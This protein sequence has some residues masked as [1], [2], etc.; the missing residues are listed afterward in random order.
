[1]PSRLPETGRPG[2]RAGWLLP[3]G[4]VFATAFA[5]FA[6]RGFWPVTPSVASPGPASASAVPVS[7]GR[8]VRTD[9]AERQ[10][11]PGTLGYRG[12][13]SVSNELPA[14]II[15]WL[16]AA[17]QVIR[18]GQALYRIDGQSVTLLYGSIP[19]WRSFQPGMTPG[20]DVRE[21]N[22]NL[23]ALGFDPDRQIALG[24]QFG[25]ATVAAVEL[26]QRAHGMPETGSIPLGEVA[27]LPGPLLISAESASMG[28]PVGAGN[29]VLSGTSTTPSVLVSLTPGGPAARA[30]DSVLVTLP[31]GTTTVPGTVTSVGRVATVS[32]QSAA[33]AQGAGSSQGSGGTQ[34]PQI[35]VTIGLRR[36]SIGSG[37]DQA[38]V[39]V[40]ITEADDRGVLAVP[41]TA[42]LAL[43]D[44]SFAVRTAGNPSRLIPVT[45]HLFD[46]VAGLVEVTGAGLGAGLTIEVAQG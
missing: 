18:R 31:N 24:D 19:A 35:P 3:A 2:Y 9:V 42:L 21:L 27:F 37:L 32:A 7:T 8:V 33:P 30:G 25:W 5:G 22:E 13:F 41:V 29:A 4:V 23:I 12:T 45:T 10:V 43:P 14:G 38:P 6:F 17:G 46:D 20:A 40:T 39:Q 28:G 11:V 26:W 44:G 36:S 34:T 15:T 1:M 16:P